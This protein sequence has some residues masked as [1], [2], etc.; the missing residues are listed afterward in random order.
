MNTGRVTDEWVDA[1]KAHAAAIDE[2]TLRRNIV[3]QQKQQAA[4][5]ASQLVASGAD[6]VLRTL[7]TD[8]TELL[9]LVADIIPD[10][11]GATTPAE[12]IAKDA[13]AAWKELTDLASKYQDIRVSQSWLMMRASSQ[14]W[15]N[16]SPDLPGEDH[17]NIAFI[18]N[19]DDIWPAWRKGGP[20]MSTVFVG[21]GAA[22]NMRHEPW[23]AEQYS[24]DMLLWLV[25]SD[26]EPWL[27]TMRELRQMWAERDTPP[28]P[29]QPDDGDESS[30]IHDSL[31]WGPQDA[32]RKRQAAG[33]KPP[34]PRRRPDYSR[35]AIP[36]THSK[37]PTG[38]GASHE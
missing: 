10:L 5:Q 13:G 24:A 21:P 2:S 29:P 36:F 32:E 9:G 3:V 28:E 15:R 1:V 17:A 12:A 23:P 20:N 14:T 27:P 4:N 26:A 11:N 34:A 25:T 19:V 8:L 35:R 18:K 7:Q 22:P 37:P 6:L 31:L 38:L 33:G 30:D 16:C